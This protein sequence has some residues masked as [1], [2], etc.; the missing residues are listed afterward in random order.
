VARGEEPGA[1]L[2]E[3][4][5]DEAIERDRTFAADQGRDGV[6]GA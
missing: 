1:G 2:V 5:L 3:R 4:G 6:G